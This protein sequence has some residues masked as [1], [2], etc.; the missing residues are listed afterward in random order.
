MN[1]YLS[2]NLALVARSFAELPQWPSLV[3]LLHDES[4]QDL[5]EYA[6]IACC[7]GLGTVTGVHGLAAQIA[8]Y[9]NIVDNTFT[10][11]ISPN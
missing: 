11:S 9:L 7:I 10:N 3:N 6:L 2:S 8:G 4:G 1:V 5:I